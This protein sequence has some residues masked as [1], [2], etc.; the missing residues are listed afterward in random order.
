MKLITSSLSIFLAVVGP[1]VAVSN[2]ESVFNNLLDSVQSPPKKPVVWRSAT[3]LVP[4]QS[5]SIAQ[6]EA[7]FKDSC[8]NPSLQFLIPTTLNDDEYDDFIIHYWCDQDENGV[9]DDQPTKDALVALKSE[10]AT[11]YLVANEAVFGQRLIGLGGAS[12]K[13]VVRDVNQD[14]YED[15]FFATN[16]E[17]GRLADDPKTNAA[18]P[19]LLMSD[20]LGRYEVVNLGRRGWGHAVAVVSLDSGAYDYVFAAFSDDSQVFRYEDGEFRDVTTDYPSELGG[21]ATSVLA[22]D[23]VSRTDYLAGSD[24]ISNG[25]FFNDVVRFYSIDASGHLTELNYAEIEKE[26]EVDFISWNGTAGQ[27]TV[28]DHNGTLYLDGAL[29]TYCTFRS[30]SD[31]LVSLL[32]GKMNAYQLKSGEPVVIGSDIGDAELDNVNFLTFFAYDSSGVYPIQSPIVDEE[33][34]VNYNFYDC[35]DINGDALDDILVY[36][37][38]Q[39]WR[40]SRVDQAGKPILYLNDGKGS[41]VWEDLSSWPGYSRR[42]VSLQSLMHDINNDGVEDLLLYGLRVDAGDIQ[43]HLMKRDSGPSPSSQLSSNTIPSNQ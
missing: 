4:K 22:I 14:G 35:R 17:D 40:N 11:S 34:L 36:G 1:S 42:N 39:P 5:F 41:L 30:P 28:I 38:T 3:D 8:E 20:G 2:P 18:P 21:W 13:Y 23:G 6:P 43:I 37:F 24:S 29:E 31:P 7:Y 16:W 10:S 27:I 19:A 12:R 33:I 26:G 25:D 9:Y 32:A 15:Y